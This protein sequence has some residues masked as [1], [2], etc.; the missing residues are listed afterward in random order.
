MLAVLLVGAPKNPN[1]YNPFGKPAD[2]VLR[3]EIVLKR[4]LDLQKKAKLALRDGVRRISP[5]LQ[6]ALVCMDPA[7][8]DVLAAVGDA[9]EVRNS[10][11]LAFISRHQPGSAIKPL[12]YAAAL[13]KGIT[14][15]SIW[16]DAPDD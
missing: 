1:H 4:R 13:E 3:R 12:I 6:G 7:T 11:N 2:V 8:G 5:N 15:G 9:E 10:I 16:S 14:A